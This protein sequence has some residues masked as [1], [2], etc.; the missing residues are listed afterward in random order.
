MQ[1][2]MQEAVS[3]CCRC[4]RPCPAPGSA[5]RAAAAGGSS[6]TQAQVQA[7]AQR[8]S[9]QLVVAQEGGHPA[10][11]RLVAMLRV[12]IVPAGA[13]GRA[14]RG[15]GEVGPGREALEASSKG[16]HCIALPSAF[17]KSAACAAHLSRYTWRPSPSV[18]P[19]GRPSSSAPHHLVAGSPSL[20][21]GCSTVRLHSTCAH[22]GESGRAA[23]VRAATRL[24]CLKAVGRPHAGLMA[25]S[26]TWMRPPN[27]SPLL[28]G[29]SLS[30]AR[31]APP[32]AA[33]EEEG[34]EP[35]GRAAELGSVMADRSEEPQSRRHFQPAVA[36]LDGHSGDISCELRWPFSHA[37]PLHV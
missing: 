23:A 32:P 6:H 15:T 22:Q 10:L 7:G 18:S 28:A 21:S 35:Q 37:T 17:T 4:S 31:S 8:S 30:G 36:H 26:L 1:G 19:S 16:W 24:L 3:C 13:G 27:S 29:R 2:R 25:V 11:V 33:A 5:G 9:S 20:P 12:C 34:W 14:G